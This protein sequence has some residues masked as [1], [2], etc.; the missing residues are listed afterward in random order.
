VRNARRCDREL[1]DPERCARLVLGEVEGAFE[2]VGEAETL[3]ERGEELRAAGLNP[4]LGLLHRAV[5]REVEGAPD[6]GHEVAPVVEVPVRDRDRVDLGPE[7][8][9]S[10]TTEHARPAVQEDAASVGIEHVP[11]VCAPRVRPGG[12]GADDGQA[13]RGILPMCRARYES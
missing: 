6:P 5:R 12:G 10:E 11:G 8:L 1:A 9:L 4:K 2:H 3:P 7:A 13:H